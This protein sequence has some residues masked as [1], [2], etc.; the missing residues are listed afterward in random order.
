MKIIC[1]L[2]GLIMIGCFFAYIAPG[3]SMFF[4]FLKPLIED[5]PLL[6]LIAFC[7]LSLLALV[8]FGS[9]SPPAKNAFYVWQP[10][11]G[12]T[13]P[14]PFAEARKN[15][16]NTLITTGDENYWWPCKTWTV[17]GTQRTPWSTRLSLA[18]FFFVL[19]T[20]YAWFQLFEEP[21]YLMASTSA[22]VLCLVIAFFLPRHR[23]VPQKP[24]AHLLSAIFCDPRPPDF[25][26]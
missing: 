7:L 15:P 25:D 12:V 17:Q 21:V 11:T 22:A 9:L 10:H 18:G 1:N 13:G 14:M 6:P 19:A 5:F 2:I 3:V 8:D 20:G 23:G 26:A 16:P 24:A 4:G